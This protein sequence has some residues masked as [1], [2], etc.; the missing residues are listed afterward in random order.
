M[1]PQYTLSY[2]AG[3][4]GSISGQ[5][6]QSVIQGNDG[7]TVTAVPDTGYSFSQ[8]SDG[9]V[10]AARTDT[11]VTADLTVTAL[12]TINRYIITY[13]AGP[14]GSISGLSPQTIAYGSDAQTVT[15]VP[16]ADAFFVGWSDGLGS[17]TRT[18]AGVT[19]PL[20][21]TCLLYTSPSPRDRQKSRM[22]SSA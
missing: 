20:A 21:V 22:P 14:H 3:A 2:T 17:A 8:W 16:S 19:G 7:T 15:A 4:H 12:F 11:N 1:P 18:D 13:S 5:A 6:P 9:L 10:T